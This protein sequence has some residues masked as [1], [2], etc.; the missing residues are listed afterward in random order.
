MK[1]QLLLLL[2]VLL[3]LS[4]FSFSP[5]TTTRASKVDPVVV[6]PASVGLSSNRLANIRTVMSRHCR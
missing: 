3:L 4:A 5:T 2:P 1:R 6:A